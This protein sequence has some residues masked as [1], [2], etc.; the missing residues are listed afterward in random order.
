MDGIQL[1]INKD[2]Q[3]LNKHIKNTENAKK[4]RGVLTVILR[5]IDKPRFIVPGFA[6]NMYLKLHIKT[7]K[8][9]T[10]VLKNTDNVTILR[11]D[12]LLFFDKPSLTW[13]ANSEYR[14]CI[15]SLRRKTRMTW[16]AKS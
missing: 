12:L 9:K 4:V 14:I 16:T 13:L 15:L 6:K 1:K 5:F 10:S 7:N 8:I 11:G 2:K 3:N